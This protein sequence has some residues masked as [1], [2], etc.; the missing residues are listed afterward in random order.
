MAAMEEVAHTLDFSHGSV[1]LNAEQYKIV[2]ADAGE[3]QR[4]LAA[5]GSGKTTTIT[6]RIA[7]LL[8]HTGV[9]AD[10]ILLLTFS[11]N[12]AND[13]L[14]RVRRLVGAAGIW[15]GTFHALAKQILTLYG[16]KDF[17]GAN[18]FIDELPVKWN[19]WLRTD[20]GR[21]WVGKLRYIVVDEVQDI[22]AIQ[23]RLMESLRHIGSRVILV[24]DDAQNIYTWRGSSAGFLLDYHSVVPSVR[25][26]QLRQNYRST[27]AIVSVANRVMRGIP[28]LP[29]KEH[30]IAAKKG[31]V[32][33][34]VLFFWRLGD[35][36]AWIAKQIAALRAVD[37]SATI[38]VLA[39]NNVDL[40]RV[41]ET[42]LQHGLKVRMLASDRKEDSGPVAS[43][44]LID[45]TTFHGSKG[46]EWDIT[47]LISLSDD[48]LPAS[49]TASAIVGERRLFYVACT[50]ARR[51][52]FLTYHGNERTLSRFVR[53]IGYQLLTFH[54]LAKY[55]LSEFEIH[56]GTPS[57]QNLL[58]CLDGDD[59]AVVRADNLLPWND[60]ADSAP[61]VQ[62]RLF[63]PG[64]SW[65]IPEWT[66]VRDFE[67]FVRLWM[68]RALLALRGWNT[69]YKDPLCER[70]IFTIR[71][72]H[73]DIGFWEQWRDDIDVALKHFF[74]DTYRFDPAGYGDVETWA[75]ERGLPWGQKEIVAATA[76]LAKLR[77][78][79]RPLRFEKI[80]LDEFT[81][82]PSNVVIPAE[83]RAD[84]LRSWRRFTN[85]AVPWRDCLVDI[86]RLACLEQVSEGR[87]ACLFRVPVMSDHLNECLPFLESLEGL[88]KGLVQD[89]SDLCLNPEVATDDVR[90]TG[91]DMLI[92][93][94]L[95]RICGER[96]PDM[97]M[98]V[99]SCLMAYLF[100]SCGLC[101]PI[102]AIQIVHP[103]HGQSWT[104]YGFDIVKTKRLYERLLAQWKAKQ[105][106]G[107]T[108]E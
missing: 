74:A 80:S 11:R 41:E 34:D 30:M 70:M 86:W 35:E 14:A 24:G 105:T 10:Q 67:A 63:A 36:H 1:R 49:K 65:R 82:R 73:E 100:M 99:E 15:A 37:A 60:T 95:V 98:W 22:N 94:T 75:L 52:M 9:R 54:G 32:K 76:L 77:G 81:V 7:W 66:D 26:Y 61:L 19:Q 72:F 68:K 92:G 12:A 101:G 33:P 40:Y 47:F 5:A 108:E 69:D 3:H 104:F 53:E 21:T 39:R 6:A 31:G 2:T 51:R 87:N 85:P 43:N 91:A 8:T 56:E 83:Y 89:D 16:G 96:R 64:E 79:L 20:R 93:S 78:Q 59:W 48:I 90:P 103:F 50:R 57:L 107:L 106:T 88:L 84:C 62:E 38:A 29:W 18:C 58:D 13:M 25:D 102:G 55:A 71:V 44:T 45:L 17:H 97:Y 27:D 46:L 23:W 4:I 28:T 42:L